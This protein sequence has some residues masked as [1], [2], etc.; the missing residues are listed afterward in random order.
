MICAKCNNDFKCNNESNC[1]CS[2]YPV[3]EALESEMGCYCPNC[4]EK[5]LADQFNKQAIITKEDKYKISQ[6]GI[7]ET[8][9]EGV[10][11]IINE[12][13]LYTF[14]KWYLL[15]RGYCCENGCQNCPY[16]FKKEQNI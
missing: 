10:D 6:L 14:T 11:F 12:S 13:G 15:R 1:W 5:R 7:P 8:P 16:N 9:I 4:L 2:H 3:L